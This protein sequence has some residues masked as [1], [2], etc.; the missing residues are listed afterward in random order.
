MLVLCQEVEFAP[1]IPGLQR[2]TTAKLVLK[3]LPLRRDE[4]AVVG[5]KLVSILGE[6]EAAC[7]TIS[8]LVSVPPPG[9]EE[10]AC[11]TIS[12]LVLV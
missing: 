7:V 1:P 5:K 3:G 10:A 11:V 12:I 2:R 9:E 4:E 6:E 8:I